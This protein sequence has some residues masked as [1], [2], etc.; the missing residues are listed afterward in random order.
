MTQW[1]GAGC[2]GVPTSM[3]LLLP[4][5]IAPGQLGCL[6]LGLSDIFQHISFPGKET[7]LA[8]SAEG[9]GQA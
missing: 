2:W 1:H 8:E 9:K 3:T 4:I 7:R 6:L 5:T